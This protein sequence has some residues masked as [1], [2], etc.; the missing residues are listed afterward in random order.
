MGL[1]TGV[2]LAKTTRP[3]IDPSNLQ[4]VAYEV[5]GPSLTEKP[6]LLRIEDIRE[7]SDIGMIIDSADEFI[8]PAD[9][10]KI[11]E[12]YEIKFILEKYPVIDQRKSKLGRVLDY[13]V[14][15]ASFKIQQLTVKRPVMKSFND[16][17]LLINRSSIKDINDSAIVIRSENE[18]RSGTARET[19]R[20]Y[21]NPFKQQSPSGVA[22]NS[23]IEWR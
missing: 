22:D 23:D 4:I 3:V 12:I 6:S 19:I 1:Q 10:I 16:S 21:S 7:I 20:K 11:Q 17:E 14:D 5:D 13:T 8:G 9:V 18:K 2:Q 15:P